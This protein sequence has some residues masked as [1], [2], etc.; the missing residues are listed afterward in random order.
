MFGVKKPP[1]TFDDPISR[2][3]V[4]EDEAKTLFEL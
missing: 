3:L 1:P 2:G 4:T